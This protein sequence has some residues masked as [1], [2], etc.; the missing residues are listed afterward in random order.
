M[1]KVTFFLASILMFCSCSSEN[2]KDSEPKPQKLELSSEITET[3]LLAVRDVVSLGYD[4]RGTLDEIECK[5]VITPLITDGKNIQNQILE[6]LSDSVS[7]E[8]I[9]FFQNLSD[10]EL[11]ALSFLVYTITPNDTNVSSRGIDTNRLLHCASV[12]VGY[13]AIKKLAVGEVV[14]AV[15]IR[16]A[17]LAIGK[18]YLGY[19]GF[20]IMIYEFVECVG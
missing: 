19:I 4:S 1:K 17:L 3:T 2:G 13:D 8:D 10:E 6:Q 18:R 15:T 20:A 9:E 7:E 12:A 11:A 5:T 14:T 16:Q